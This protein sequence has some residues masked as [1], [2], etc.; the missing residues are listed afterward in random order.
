MVAVVGLLGYAD[1]G[2]LCGYGSAGRS[3][4]RG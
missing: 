1:D 3:M 4:I 2:G